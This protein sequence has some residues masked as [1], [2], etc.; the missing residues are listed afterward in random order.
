MEYNILLLDFFDT[1]SNNHPKSRNLFGIFCVISKFISDYRLIL[2]IN[3]IIIIIN[4]MG[5][6][7]VMV[8]H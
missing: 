5:N 6:N 7:I 8:I 3:F 1:G 2:N 4:W